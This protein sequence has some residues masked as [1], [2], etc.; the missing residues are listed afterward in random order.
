MTGLCTVYPTF[1]RATIGRLC[2]MLLLNYWLNYFLIITS[3][4]AYENRKTKPKLGYFRQYRNPGKDLSSKNGP[5]GHPVKAPVGVMVRCPSTLVH[6]VP[7]TPCY[8]VHHILRR[9]DCICDPIFFKSHG[10]FCSPLIAQAHSTVKQHTTTNNTA[11][12]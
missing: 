6:I 1:S 3:N 2:I 4:S 11:I 5:Y 8:T 10:Q 7:L 12:R 9:K